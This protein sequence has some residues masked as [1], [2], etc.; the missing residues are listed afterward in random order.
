MAR[1]WGRGEAVGRGVAW[2]RC[3]QTAEGRSRS[4][5]G[6]GPL[7]TSPADTARGLGTSLACRPDWRKGTG[8]GNGACQLS[9]FPSGQ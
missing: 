7:L 4:Q 9:V 1:P 2:A 8:K 6:A 3:D 5:G